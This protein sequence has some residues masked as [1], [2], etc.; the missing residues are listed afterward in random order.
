MMNN[1]QIAKVIVLEIYD[2]GSVYQ[3]SIEDI[4]RCQKFSL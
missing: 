1:V 4:H 2:L 3:L